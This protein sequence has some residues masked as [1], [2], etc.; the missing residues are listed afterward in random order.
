MYFS[1]SSKNSSFLI[2]EPCSSSLDFNNTSKK[3]VVEKEAILRFLVALSGS[4]TSESPGVLGHHNDLWVKESTQVINIMACHLFFLEFCT[5]WLLARHKVREWYLKRFCYHRRWAFLDRYIY[6]NSPRCWT[7][8]LDSHM[9]HQITNWRQLTF[10][11]F[12]ALVSL[13]NSSSPSFLKYEFFFRF[14]VQFLGHFCTYWITDKD[15]LALQ[16]Y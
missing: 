9:G 15:M 10:K 11:L 4:G 16:Y 5:G 13:W 12:C 1:T 6:T 14:I 2:L 7:N 8:L 3:A